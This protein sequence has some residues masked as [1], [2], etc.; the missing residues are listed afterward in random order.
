M[1]SSNL[2][3]EIERHQDLSKVDVQLRDTKDLFITCPPLSGLSVFLKQ[4][5]KH[6]LVSDHFREY[7]TLLFDC[8]TQNISKNIFDELVSFA[9]NDL[10]I[11]RPKKLGK[12]KGK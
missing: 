1:A 4:I 11:P 7:K 2:S 5:Q 10:G 12:D 6:I 8:K 3:H 9:I